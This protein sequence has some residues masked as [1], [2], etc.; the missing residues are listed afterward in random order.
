MTT[1]TDYNQNRRREGKRCD[2]KI[3]EEKRARVYERR[4]RKFELLDVY[5][6][7]DK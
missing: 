7:R 5:A 2:K 6:N 4:K 1:L 3:E